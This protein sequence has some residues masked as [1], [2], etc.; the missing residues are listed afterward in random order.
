MIL[1]SDKPWRYLLVS[2]IQ[3]TLRFQVPTKKVLWDALIVH[4][5]EEGFSGVLAAAHHEHS[6]DDSRSQSFSSDHQLRV[7]LSYAYELG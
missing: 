2:S 7:H 4:D 5:E 6:F 1:P 3:Q